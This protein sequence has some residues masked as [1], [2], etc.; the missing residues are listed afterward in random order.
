MKTLVHFDD[1]MNEMASFARFQDS[2]QLKG[3]EMRL[4]TKLFDHMKKHGKDVR[5]TNVH[6]NSDK[7]FDLTYQGSMKHGNQP[8]KGL[9]AWLPLAAVEE[10]TKEKPGKTKDEQWAAFDEHIAP[11]FKEVTSFGK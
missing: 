7:I 3:S 5:V 8:G 4:F 1:F 2:A 10:L 6:R 9:N 11:M